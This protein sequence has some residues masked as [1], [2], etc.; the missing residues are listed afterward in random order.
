MNKCLLQKLSSALSFKNAI[1]Q[2]KNNIKLSIS[3]EFYST[4]CIQKNIL[5]KH[6]QNNQKNK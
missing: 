1:K 6:V 2:Q 4:F 3:L 5:P